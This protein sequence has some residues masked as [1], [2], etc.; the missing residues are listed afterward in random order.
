MISGTVAQLVADLRAKRISSV[1]LTRALLARIDQAQGR[2]N[3]FVTVDAEGAL[4][5][6]RAAD[7]ALARGNAP[8]LAGIPIA[9]KD[10]IMTDGLRTA[11]GSPTVSAPRRGVPTRGAC[12]PP[13]LKTAHCCSARGP[14]AMHAILRRLMGRVKITRAPSRCG[15]RDYGGASPGSTWARLSLNM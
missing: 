8:P 6:A 13:P 1:E 15:S 14:A 10:V 12:S 11:C 3:A 7:A 9:H 5:Q 4:A 2:F